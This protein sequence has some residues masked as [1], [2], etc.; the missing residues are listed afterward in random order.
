M[1]VFT[2]CRGQNSIFK[3][4]GQGQ[5]ATGLLIKDS[6]R[7]AG[8]VACLVGLADHA[9]DGLGVLRRRESQVKR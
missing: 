6:E 5:S 2:P 7:L 9:A 8:D 3:H 4:V 1:I